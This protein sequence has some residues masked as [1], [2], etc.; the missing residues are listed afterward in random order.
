[1]QRRQLENSNP[2]PFRVQGYKRALETLG[3]DVSEA[4]ADAITDLYTRLHLGEVGDGHEER[5]ARSG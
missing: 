3:L 2:M 1:M 5:N 4:S